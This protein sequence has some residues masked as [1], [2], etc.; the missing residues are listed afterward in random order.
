MSDTLTS[1]G[2]AATLAAAFVHARLKA[3]PLE[4]YPGPI[5]AALADAYAVQD[6]A[7][8]LWPDEVA[9][10]KIGLIMPHMREMYGEARIA[11]P[12]F[13]KQVRFAQA[14]TLVELPVFA[15]GFAA[16]EAEFV[17]RIGKDAPPGRTQWT[18]EDAAD[19]ADAMYIGVESAGSPLAAIN[20][21]GPAVT[22]SDFGNNAGLVIGAAV[23]NWRS[24]P[25]PLLTTETFIDGVLVGRGS[26]AAVP[27]GPFAALAFI[28]ENAARRGRPLRAGYWISTG[29]TTGVHIIKP[30]QSARCDFGAFGAV[31][32]RAVEAG[33]IA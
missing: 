28:L 17:L 10:W 7:I 19:H 29:A 22:A 21:L 26:A 30:G 14:G 4:A 3:A 12:I 18:P 16:V 27:D 25:W 20:D 13:R 9:G 33:A 24:T 2:S 11:G 31:E 6:A 15:G 5:P 1:N 32:C 23:E 8:D